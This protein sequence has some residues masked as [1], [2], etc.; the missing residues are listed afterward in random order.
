MAAGLDQVYRGGWSPDGTLYA[1]NL[2]T[3]SGTRLVLI[4]VSDRRRVVVARG[5]SEGKVVWTGP[6][7]LLVV[8]RSPDRLE[9]V[10]V[11]GAVRKMNA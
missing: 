11:R 3:R 2:P 8:R 10:D 4:R 9:L 1:V 5:S 6:H 7:T